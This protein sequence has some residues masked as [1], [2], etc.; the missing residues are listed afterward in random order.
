MKDWEVRK[1]NELYGRLDTLN[2]E[3]ER[4]KQD[5]NVKQ[6]VD[7]LDAIEQMLVDVLAAVKPKRSTKK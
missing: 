4:L 3:N 2:K 1:V 5:N 6:F 7:R